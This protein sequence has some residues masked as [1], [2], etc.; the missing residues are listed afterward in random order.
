LTAASYHAGLADQDRTAIQDRFMAGEIDVLVATNAFGM[1]VDKADIRLV[2][3]YDM[4]GSLEAYYQE[5]GRAGRDGEPARC[6]M[7][8][9]G[10]DYHL[11]RFFVDNANPDP[12]LVQRL[13]TI[14]AHLSDTADQQRPVAI[15]ALASQTDQ[16][17]DGALRTALR[18][19]Q[20]HGLIQIEGSSVYVQ[21]D[22]PTA[23]PVDVK[24]MRDKRQRDTDRLAKMVQYTR[25]AAGCRFDRIREYFVGRKGEP[26]GR[27]DACERGATRAR[28]GAADLARIKTVL[29]A[30]RRLNFRFGPHR[31]VQILV[32]SRVAEI[33]QR[34]LE[35]QP[36]F[37]ALADE[38]PPSI[39]GLIDW[40]E[41]CELLEFEPF[42]TQGGVRAHV[43]G[44]RPAAAAI[45]SQAE[46]PELPEVP[47]ALRKGSGARSRQRGGPSGRSA[48]AT[49]TADPG[50][51]G[52]VD[53]VLLDAL[54]RY[55]STWAR[56]NARPP[57]MMCANTALDGL[58][59]AKPRNEQEF[60]AVKG[61]GPRKWEEFGE[62]LVA[63]IQACDQDPREQSA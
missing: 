55:R 30:V 17:N 46:V 24:T 5:A 19:L 14:F 15:D 12:A 56:S 53:P 40:L 50:P 33:L 54:K 16:K 11:Q 7:F 43:V 58:A 31:I 59:A 23:C 39:R 44:I 34:G 63:I 37:G 1:G 10:G 18:M 20:L 36:E 4:P 45:L 35:R 25:S 38:A 49:A 32:G 21:S 62:D 60:L 61:L 52:A 6:V 9:H 13:F 51:T 42:E 28:P 8:Q 57:Y 48:T 27:C 2:L 29:A 26:C 41:E 47:P 3:H 22:F